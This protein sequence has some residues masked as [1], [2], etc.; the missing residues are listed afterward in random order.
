MN[1][2]SSV[3]ELA[4]THLT[5]FEILSFFCNCLTSEEDFYRVKVI[6]RKD[7]SPILNLYL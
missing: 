2:V 1:H 3:P 7:V 4:D 5:V 6:Q